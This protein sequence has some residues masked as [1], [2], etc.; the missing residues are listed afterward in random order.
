M[1]CNLPGSESA[2]ILVHG[3]WMTGIEMRLLA[4]RLRGHGFTP[5]IFRYFSRNASLHEN[6]L[7]LERFCSK[8]KTH[9]LRFVC[10]SYGGILLCSCLQQK[11]A[12][13]RKIRSAVFLGSPLQGAA[14]A[15]MLG[16]TL[17]GAFA[18]GKSIPALIEGC[19]LIDKPQFP[20]GM[21]T[22]TI[23]IGLGMFLLMGAGESDGMVTAQDTSAPWVSEHV[24]VRTTHLGLLFSRQAGE[25]TARFLKKGTFSP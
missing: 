18:M 23:N 20:T 3:L 21:I 7:R 17:P 25:L 22:G 11:L 5:G 19:G 9:N 12:F 16:H 24:R 6:T 13:T 14:V 1:M 15:R 2:V 8:I 10:H 4:G